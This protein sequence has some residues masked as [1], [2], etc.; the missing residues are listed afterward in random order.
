ATNQFNS[1]TKSNVNHII[2]NNNIVSNYK[3]ADKIENYEDKK[4]TIDKKNFTIDEFLEYLSEQI[5]L[6]QK[7]NYL[8]NT[9]FSLEFKKTSKLILELQKDIEDFEIF[10][11]R[12]EFGEYYDGIYCID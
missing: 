12:K 3:A 7:N 2:I 5:E 6:L 1:T 11:L 4:Y 10:H 9:S 8:I